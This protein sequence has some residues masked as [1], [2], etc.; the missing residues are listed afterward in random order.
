MARSK[1]S[2]GINPPSSARARRRRCSATGS[3]VEELCTFF[4]TRAYRAEVLLIDDGRSRE[5]SY[6]ELLEFFARSE[7]EYHDVLFQPP[8]SGE[9]QT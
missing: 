3:G 4:H 8:V 7:A 6:P 2:N 1:P 5:M 9:G